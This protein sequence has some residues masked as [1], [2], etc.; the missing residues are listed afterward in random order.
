MEMDDVRRSL[1]QAAQAQPGGV[2]FALG[3]SGVLL[4]GLSLS[5]P[6]FVR[7]FQPVLIGTNIALDQ[8][9]PPKPEPTRQ[10]TDIKHA[11]PARTDPVDFTL[12]LAPPTSEGLIDTRV[13]L[14]PIQP[15]LAGGANDAGTGATPPHMA[16]LLEPQLDSRYIDAFQPTYPSDERLARHAGRVVVRV[17][18]GTDGRVK[19]VQQVSAASS[20]FSR[21]RAGRRW[22]DGGSGRA[23]A[24]ASR[25][26]HGGRW[27]CAS[28]STRDDATG[29]GRGGAGIASPP[30]LSLVA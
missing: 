8:P 17:L 7:E 9:P 13:D 27:R 11:A 15:P 18:I 2:A 28:C 26:R 22:P 23:R 1:C 5:A 30:R 29:T 4:F 19:D 3:A 25:S 10:S 24:T 16:V 6:R 21:R 12:L 20:A 14:L